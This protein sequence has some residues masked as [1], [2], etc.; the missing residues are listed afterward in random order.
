MSVETE[1]N[2]RTDARPSTVLRPDRGERP[3]LFV[4][5]WVWDF[6]HR[7]AVLALTATVFVLLYGG[8]LDPGP[9]E[10]RLGLA[11]GESLGPFGQVFGSWDPSIWPGRLAPSL[12]WAWGEG[13]WPTSASIRWPSAI[14]G[15]ILGLVLARH[16]ATILGGRAGVLVGLCWYGSLALMDRSAGAGIDLV[17][18]LGTV[19]VLDRLLGRGS[20]LVAGTCLAWAFLAGGWPPVVVVLLVTVVLGRPGS[21]IS[22]RLLLPPALAAAGWSLWAWSVAPT[23]AWAAALTL[24]LTEGPSWWL[25]PGVVALALP[26]SPFAALVAGRSV[27]EGMPTEGRAYVLGWLQ[28]AGACLIV[29]TVV[30]GL[31]GASRIPALAGLAVA[32]A[33]GCDR[34]LAGDGGERARRWYF[35]VILTMLFASTG[36]ALGAGGYLAAAVSYYRAVCILLIVLTVAATAL[37]VWSA[38]RRHAPGAFFAVV[39]LA[40]VLKLA[41]AGYYV[42]EWN[43]RRSQGPWGRAVGQWIPPNW[44]IYTTHTW[45]T[46]LAFATGHPFRQLISAQHLAYQPEGVRFVLL[47]DT[48]F[49]NWPAQAPALR[50]VAS[51]QD[52]YG[53]GR[54]LARTDGPLPGDPLFRAGGSR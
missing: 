28:A 8:N 45:R 32:A 26:W 36:L 14:A 20:D 9:I 22:A 25:A 37:A 29:G 13:G 4:V 12:I 49:A 11:S 10:S 33:A 23:E 1:Q 31:A 51:F 5:R 39:V 6:P 24:P 41:Y 38:S 46:D 42:P 54:V 18:A 21:S 7:F 44:P 16:A 52:E 53:G 15:V 47:L 3:T 35:G 30:P 34:V 19:A 50:R 40:V 27:R 43:Y 17:T 48:E 2:A